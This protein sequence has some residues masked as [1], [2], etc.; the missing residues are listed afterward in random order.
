MDGI[1]YKTQSYQETSKLLFVYTKEGKK[2]LLAQGSQKMTSNIRMA[3]QYLTYIRFEDTKGKDFIKVYDLEIL[4]DF[5]ALKTSY[6]SLALASVITETIQALLVDDTDAHV[7]ED[8]IEVLESNTLKEAVLK[9]LLRL[10]S[11]LGY[12]IILEGNGKK[13]KGF[14]MIY[15]RLI[16]QDEEHSVDLN[17][18][19]T[20]HLLKLLKIPYQRLETLDDKDYQT[21]KHFIQKYYEYHLQYTIKTLK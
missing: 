9:Y 12:P 18:Y 19:E 3:A 10:L 17:E 20:I 15:G 7:F 11:V 1:V 8:M 14:S 6:A 4:N 21:L 13:I 16:Y 2:T 5:Q